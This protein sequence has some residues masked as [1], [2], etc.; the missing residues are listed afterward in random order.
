[1][2]NKIEDVAVKL[3]GVMTAGAV[4]IAVIPLNATMDAALAE[5]AKVGNRFVNALE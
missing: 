4:L 5:L 2:L 3:A 1:M